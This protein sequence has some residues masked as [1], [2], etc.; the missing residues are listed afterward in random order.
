MEDD[1]CR[2]C[3]I[4]N[5]K[6]YSDI[7]Y[8][9]KEFMI[10]LDKI[11]I[12]KGHCLLIPK[13]HYVTIMDTP[14][15]MVEKAFLLAKKISS[16]IKE[17]I[18]CDGILLL[19]NNVVSQSVPHLHIHVIPRKKGVVLKGFMWPREGY[20]SEDEAK[21]FAEAIKRCINRDVYSEEGKKV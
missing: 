2:F 20:S 10:F 6:I 5:R 1:A 4:A 19:V 14:D 15:M 17:A 7:V 18:N 9:D 21:K 8:E 12:F 11:P 3:D 16:S 13:A